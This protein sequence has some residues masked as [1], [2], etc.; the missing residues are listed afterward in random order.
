M[1]N[2][3]II[4]LLLGTLI[5]MNT[6]E[7]NETEVPEIPE[8]PEVP[9]IPEIPPSNDTVPETPKE[10]E[11]PP[12]KPL[13]PPSQIPEAKIILPIRRIGTSKTTLNSAPCGS[14]QK[15]KADTLTNKGSILHFIWETVVPASSGNCT[16]KI[17]PGIENEA[18]F[19]T[20]YP[21]YTKSGKNGEFSCGRSK[22]FE[23]QQFQLPPDFECDGCTLQWKWNTPY[24]DVYSCSDI[25]IN[26]DLMGACMAK[27]QNGGSCFNGKCICL[28]GFS[29]EFCEDEGG[30]GI[31]WLL[32]FLFILVIAA[33]VG[34]SVYLI[35]MKCF[36]SWLGGKT[37]I[38]EQFKEGNDVNYMIDSQAQR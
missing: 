6:K 10:P 29:G 35:R 20:L 37:K 18:N 28:K 38:D 22:G 17:S 25:M 32:V 31:N 8:M 30:K 13:P 12:K 4:V 5:G 16:V 2:S 11:T 21:L 14:I 33:I 15:L 19:T 1:K 26:G 34:L 7:Q 23:H 24:G 9:E 36:G 27:C 3:F